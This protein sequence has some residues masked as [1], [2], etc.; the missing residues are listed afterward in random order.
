VEPVSVGVIVA[1]LLAKAL[2][3]AED[4]AIDG[5][6]K[7]A[8]KAVETLR[9]RFLGDLEAEEALEGL[10]D[11]PDS[12]RRERAL[13]E[14]LEAR[15]ERSPELLDE[16]RAIVDQAKGVGVR[17]DSIEQVAEGEG[18]VQNAGNV[19]SEINVH[20]DASPRPRD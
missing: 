16:L 17:I 10:V 15:A 11:A 13:A 3:R 4:G 9:K 6:V 12:E 8:R 14:M 2:N 20:P 1:A 19:N 7:V 18:N 5:A